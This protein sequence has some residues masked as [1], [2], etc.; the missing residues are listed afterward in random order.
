M[1]SLVANGTFVWADLVTQPAFAGKLHASQL[2]LFLLEHEAAGA[3]AL[4]P[5]NEQEIGSLLERTP[6]TDNDD[7]R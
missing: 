5:R 1:T 6:H 3:S 2:Q 7:R 4:L